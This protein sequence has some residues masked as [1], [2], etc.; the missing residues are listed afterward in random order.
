MFEKCS[1]NV[2]NLQKND[3]KKIVLRSKFTQ[4]FTIVINLINEINRFNAKMST[5]SIDST[6]FDKLISSTKSIF[7]IIHVVR[8]T[9]VISFN[10]L[11]INF[12][13]FVTKTFHNQ[14]FQICFCNSI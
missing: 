13:Y 14:Y 8:F 7:K 1:K 9:Q 10:N 11:L 6:S 4:T 12:D 3:L 2:Q 5:I